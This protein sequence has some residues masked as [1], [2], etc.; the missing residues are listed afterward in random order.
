MPE[1]TREEETQPSETERWQLLAAHTSA[2]MCL[3]TRST[4]QRVF[5]S[6]HNN[7][8]LCF[9][10]ACV[11]G[12]VLFRADVVEYGPIQTRPT[13]G[14]FFCRVF[15]RGLLHRTVHCPCSVGWTPSHHPHCAAFSLFSDHCFVASLPPTLEPIVESAFTAQCCETVRCTLHPRKFGLL[16]Q[17]MDPGTRFA[18]PSLNLCSSNLSLLTH[19]MR[20]RAEMVESTFRTT[21][22]R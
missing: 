11:F 3:Q 4:I 10:L 14:G 16:S 15:Q 1:Q 12:I 21:A 8:G 19:G 22:D 18:R 20:L 13:C 2:A 7:V 9:Y 5:Y 17:P 6:Q